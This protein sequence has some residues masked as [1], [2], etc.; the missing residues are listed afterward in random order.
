MRAESRAYIGV[1]AEWDGQKYKI[2]KL[3]FL[4]EA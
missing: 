3:G 2:G 1:D 4:P